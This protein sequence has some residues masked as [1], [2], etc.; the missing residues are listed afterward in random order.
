[1]RQ[2]FD[3]SNI[4]PLLE[5]AVFSSKDAR[6]H[7]INPSLLCYYARKGLIKKVGHGL[8]QSRQ[9]ALPVAHKYQPFLYAAKS[10]SQGVICLQ[11]ALYLQQLTRSKGQLMTIAVPNNTTKPNRAG[12]EFVRMR[13]M[14]T[15]L[16]Q[17]DLEGYAVACFDKERSILDLFRMQ[18]K[19]LALKAL[20]KAINQQL[21]DIEKLK[22]YAKK[23]RL[24]I[25]VYLFALT[26]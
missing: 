9:H 1:M 3:K 2:E 5:Q 10:I 24:D 4:Q 21:I 6:E 20:K 17:L 26:L 8:Y 11:S 7:G 16:I 15:G 22:Q 18:D 13:D 12:M 19:A 14:T 23:M 25:S